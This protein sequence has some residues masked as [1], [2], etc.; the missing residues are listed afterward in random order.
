MPIYEYQAEDGAQGCEHCQTPF[1][2]LQ[3]LSDTPLTACPKCAGPVGRIIS[4]PAVG[5]SQ[6]NHDQKAKEAGFHKLER[7]G[8]GEYEKKY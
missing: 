4:A 1:E 7:R 5:S 8:K 3:G 2:V 6:S